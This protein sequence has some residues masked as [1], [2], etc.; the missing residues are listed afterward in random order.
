VVIQCDC[1]CLYSFLEVCAL[2]SAVKIVQCLKYGVL[3][4]NVYAVHMQVIPIDFINV[5]FFQG[6]QMSALSSCPYD[7][8]GICY[9]SVCMPCI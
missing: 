1:C 2:I 6:I 7:I 9:C 3:C 4:V 5:I 8:H